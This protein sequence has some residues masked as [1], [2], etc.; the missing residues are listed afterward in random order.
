MDGLGTCI[1]ALFGSFL[2]TT[3]YLGHPIHKKYGATAGYSILNA[4]VFF[5]VLNAGIYPLIEAVIPY[6]CVAPIL[7]VVG[8]TV[9]ANALDVSPRRHTVAIFI[10]LFCVLADYIQVEF[11]LTTAFGA[12]VVTRGVFSAGTAGGIM[13]ALVLTAIVCDLI[14]RK[15]L[16]AA[17]FCAIA[18]WFSM[19][20]LMHSNNLQAGGGVPK[21]A[22]GLRGCR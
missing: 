13:N 3:V 22:L 8:L 1:G 19:F 7:M 21:A 9:A 2:P 20:G 10:G 18:C 5:T 15:F 11:G 12:E 4:V 17:V 16:R 14:D 6:A